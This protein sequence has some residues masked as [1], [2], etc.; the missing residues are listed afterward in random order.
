MKLYIIN[1]P[2]FTQN[3][4]NATKAFKPIFADMLSRLTPKK[5]GDGIQ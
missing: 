1:H 3:N 2:R 5:A 4:L